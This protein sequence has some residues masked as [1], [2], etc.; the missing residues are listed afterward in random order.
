[1][2]IPPYICDIIGGH[3]YIKGDSSNI[4]SDL[5][6]FDVVMDSDNKLKIPFDN[7]VADLAAN[8]DFINKF[9]FLLDIGV[10]LGR[11]Y[12]LT[13]DPAYTAQYLKD[14][15]VKIKSYQTISFSGQGDFEIEE[16]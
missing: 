15:G 9:I 11:D 3:I 8:K 10:C 6:K 5:N 13:Y 14:N 1:M 16:H 4:I 2:D 7:S 12:K